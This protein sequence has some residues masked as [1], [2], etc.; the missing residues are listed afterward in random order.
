M[1]KIKSKYMEQE[2]WKDIAG[3]EGLYAVSNLGRVKRVRD[4]KIRIGRYRV[5]PAGIVQTHMS[6]RG[7]D[8]LYIRGF[9][10][11]VH[12]LVARAFCKGYEDGKEVN[13]KDFNKQNNRAENLEWVTHMENMQHAWQNG[14]IKPENSCYLRNNKY[15]FDYTGQSVEDPDEW[16]DDLVRA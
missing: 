3:L 13:H 11:S 8:V 12:R 6:S 15:G 7:Y 2:Q 4:I 10:Y 5:L 1:P 16:M 9:C 14:R